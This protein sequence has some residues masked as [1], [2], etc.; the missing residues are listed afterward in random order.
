MLEAIG[1]MIIRVD[2][3]GKRLGVFTPAKRAKRLKSNSI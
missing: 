3:P 2:N 1:E